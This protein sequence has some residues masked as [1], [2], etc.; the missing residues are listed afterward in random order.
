MG[1][2]LGRP[3]L[4]ADKKRKVFPLRFSDDELALFASAAGAKR[5]P[6][7]RW[8]GLTLTDAAKREIG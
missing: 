3:K 7:R 6:L 1:K 2:K 4:P 8:I 5:L